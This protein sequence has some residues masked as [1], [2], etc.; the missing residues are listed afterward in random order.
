MA[1]QK[2]KTRPRT[3]K[4]QVAMPGVAR[5]AIEVGLDLS[6]VPRHPAPDYMAPTVRSGP[7][8]LFECGQFIP[9]PQR[10]CEHQLALIVGYEWGPNNNRRI[11]HGWVYLLVEVP[12]GG[13]PIVN[14]QP[15]TEGRRF[16]AGEEEM[17]K[18]QREANT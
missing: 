18:W 2:S 10:V 5:P 9:T 12:K 15:W 17:A 1:A 11:G 7:D 16:Q 6:R 8:P 4:R 3:V 13:F 14:G